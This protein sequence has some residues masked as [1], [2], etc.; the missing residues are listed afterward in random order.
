[1]TS[2]KAEVH[3]PEL[4]KGSCYI[5]SK[6]IESK[7]QKWKVISPNGRSTILSSSGVT[8]HIRSQPREIIYL[9]LTV[10]DRSFGQDRSVGHFEFLTPLGLNYYQ[11]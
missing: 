5:M 11:I 4:K 6:Y 1:M 2:C 9:L 10:L 8:C 3:T 7:Y